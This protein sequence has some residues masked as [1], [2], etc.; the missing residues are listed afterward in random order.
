[1][2]SFFRCHAGKKIVEYVEVLLARGGARYTIAFEIII[3]RL[4]AG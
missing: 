4:D 1:M 3:E 2:L